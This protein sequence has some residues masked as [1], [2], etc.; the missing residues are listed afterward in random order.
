[1]VYY[2]SSSNPSNF[3]M[4]LTMDNLKKK[5]FEVGPAGKQSALV[6][7]GASFGVTFILFLLILMIAKPGMC[8]TKQDDGTKKFSFGK[9]FGWSLFFGLLASGGFT[10]FLKY[11]VE[12][13]SS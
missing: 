13:P 10:A 6:L 5:E 2:L 12:N 9:A 8:C 1:M 4:D 3:K 11:G 7:L